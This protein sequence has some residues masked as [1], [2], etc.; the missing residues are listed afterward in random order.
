MEK[1]NIEIMDLKALGKPEKF[2]GEQ[3]EWYDWSFHFRSYVGILPRGTELEE[4]MESVQHQ[5]DEVRLQ[6][7]GS[8]VRMLSGHLYHLL[9]L[10]CTSTALGFV[11]KV[12]K[13]N[14][15]EAWRLLAR[16]FDPIRPGSQLATLRSIMNFDFKTN[17]CFEKRL[18][19]FD[20]L[21]NEFEKAADPDTVDDKIKVAIVVNNAPDGYQHQLQMNSDRFNTYSELR[22]YI[23]KYMDAKRQG[24][25]PNVS[26]KNAPAPMEVD[27]VYNN[28]GNYN[29]YGNHNKG[30]GKGKFQNTYN[31][32]YGDVKGKSKGKG[33]TQNSQSQNYKG[34]SQGK[35]KN[36]TVDTCYNCG[37]QGHRSTSCW[38]KKIEAVE[39]T[40]SSAEIHAIM[41]ESNIEMD[42][43]F[44]INS[45]RMRD[46]HDVHI[47]VD[48]GAVTSCCPWRFGEDAPLEQSKMANK[49]IAANKSP[50]TGYGC[51]KLD[52]LARTGAF[53]RDV[54]IPNMHFEVAD[55][56]R[57]ILSVS[58]MCAQ[59]YQVT[60]DDNPRIEVGMTSIPL[61]RLGDMY[62]LKCAAKSAESN[63]DIEK[64]IAPVVNVDEYQDEYYSGPHMKWAPEVVEGDTLMEHYPEV[65]RSHIPTLMTAPKEP[66]KKEREAHEATHLPYQP[67]C[68]VCVQAKGKDS[69]HKKV[70]H[71]DEDRLPLVCLDYFFLKTEKD[72]TL[73]TCLAAVIPTSGYGFSCV[74]D[75]KG[76]MCPSAMKGFTKFLEE[77]GVMGDAI[78]KTDKETTIR[79]FARYNASRIRKSKTILR[80]SPK[81][82]HQSNGA[83]ERFIQSIEGQIRAI[84]IS[85]EKHFEAEDGT[86]T[87]IIGA[88]SNILDWSVRHAAW[89]WN[90][91][92][93]SS[94]GE[95]PHKRQ[96]GHDYSSP[97]LEFGETILARTPGQRTQNKLDSNWSSGIWLGRSG[98]SDER[99]VCMDG[100]VLSC[101]TVRRTTSEQR[102]QIEMLK[103]ITNSYSKVILD[104]IKSNKEDMRFVH[105]DMELSKTL[106]AQTSKA[107]KKKPASDSQQEEESDKK[108]EKRMSQASRTLA[109]FH[110]DCGHTPGCR[111]CMYGASGRSHSK[112]C[113]ERKSAWAD[114]KAQKIDEEKDD[115]EHVKKKVKIDKKDKSD[116]KPAASASSSSKRV[117]VS[118]D[119]EITDEETKPIIKQLK[120]DDLDEILEETST[121]PHQIPVDDDDEYDDIDI[122]LIE[123]VQGESRT[124]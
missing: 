7:L 81:G 22:K 113:K 104:Q 23:E 67:W 61:T 117:Y 58:Q 10:T 5:E 29:G 20:L 118:D 25:T 4:M 77:A 48:S 106:N 105:P 124:R 32:Q 51:R 41:M 40:Q 64:M 73:A 13:G 88:D 19:E 3:S 35:G 53:T 47:L 31:K 99:I 95:T 94:T 18:N 80:C 98:L 96:I 89:Q 115:D 37:K 30:K 39:T 62:F 91:F 103:K 36:P 11:R 27:A 97:V 122:N 66:T 110:V 86:K 8:D 120:K 121:S 24:S 44:E 57:P 52:L 63:R 6:D 69:P 70:H 102:W 54:A 123:M 114:Q 15:L 76:A 59:G 26:E 74:V 65:M 75:T 87:E 45:I 82:S 111:A 42:E 100:K 92:H 43:L 46:P 79:D 28:Y 78:F 71:V 72:E 112:A 2:S 119:E 50:I 68:Q 84:K 12:N 85:L 34:K 33:K 109:E 55:V 14:G 93:V 60:F 17:E 49:L 108:V 116:E 90:R 56:G 83:V 21:V 101:R 1:K 16:R 38:N 9:A 107:T